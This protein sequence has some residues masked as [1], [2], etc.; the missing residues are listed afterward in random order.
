M[1]YTRVIVL[2]INPHRRSIEI[3]NHGSR[4]NSCD[5]VQ[6]ITISGQHMIDDRFSTI[7][8]AATAEKITK[9]NHLRSLAVK[10]KEHNSVEKEKTHKR[11]SC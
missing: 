5:H 2:I 8:G 1:F 7:A 10:A 3:R 11:D 9:F 6:A 4:P